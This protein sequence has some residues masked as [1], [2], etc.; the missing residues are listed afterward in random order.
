MSLA[1]ARPASSAVDLDALS[2]Q[3]REAL[4]PRWSSFLGKAAVGLVLAVLL[5]VS[6]YP[7]EVNNWTFLITDA[8]NMAVFISDFLRPDFTDLGLFVEKMVETV[9]IALWGSA[10]SIVVGVP[11]GLLSSNNIAPAWV[12]QPMRRLMDAARAINELVFAILFVAAVGLGPFAGVMALFIHNLGVISKLFSE[13]VEAIDP[14][15]V[16]GIRA[17]GASRLQQVIYGVIPQVLPLWSSFSLY[18]FETLVR[19]ATVLG[20]VGAGGI[21]FTFYESFRAFQ[22]DRAAAVIVVVV[23]VVSLIDILSSQLRRRLI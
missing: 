12:V 17:T 16:E 18:R 6:Y 13:A 7:V 8:D 11:C 20:I 3:V 23:I 19:S 5:G 2:P 22:Y 21:G 14:R 15:P 10:L 4:K 9:Q 1:T